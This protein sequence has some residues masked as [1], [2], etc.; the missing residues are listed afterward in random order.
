M[1]NSPASSWFS[2]RFL[3]HLAIKRILIP[4]G[5]DGSRSLWR[6][7][8]SS[9]LWTPAEAALLGWRNL[10]RF[11]SG[12]QVFVVYIRRW[13]SGDPNF[14][15]FWCEQ[16]QL[17]GLRRYQVPHLQ[18]LPSYPSLS[19]SYPQQLTA[20]PQPD[21]SN[22]SHPQNSTVHNHLPLLWCS[23]FSWTSN[24]S[25]FLISSSLRFWIQIDSIFSWLDSIRC[26][27][28]WAASSKANC[29]C[30]GWQ[31]LS[32]ML[33]K[34]ACSAGCRC[35]A[36]MI[37]LFLCWFCGDLLHFWCLF[38][39]CLLEG[40]GVSCFFVRV[41]CRRGTW[42]S[43]HSLSW[44]WL[45]PFYPCF[46]RWGCCFMNSIFW[47]FSSARYTR[48]WLILSL[49]HKVQYGWF[50]HLQYW[51]SSVFFQKSG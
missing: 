19:L 30:L 32:D 14:E 25:L 2:V 45:A 26:R 35:L 49:L 12:S 4:F 10:N 36:G 11:R 22:P 37:E 24:T 15:V 48:N 23:P 16:V 20:L 27:S 47:T 6:G 40:V 44:C 7:C 9:L 33:W 39:M 29:C 50:W 5:D 3:F 51:H 41:S 21:H 34:S 43:S 42:C 13:L 46:W 1:K 8:L 31:W 18:Q 17:A 28:F 38:P